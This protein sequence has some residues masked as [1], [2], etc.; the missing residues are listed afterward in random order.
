VAGGGR[1]RNHR[2]LVFHRMHAVH[3]LCMSY[4]RVRE[5]YRQYA[6]VVEVAKVILLLILKTYLNFS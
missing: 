5:L 3:N 6:E 2:M 1:G 4:Y